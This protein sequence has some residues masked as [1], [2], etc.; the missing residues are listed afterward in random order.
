MH[1]R[2]LIGLSEDTLYDDEQ[3]SALMESWRMADGGQ[4]D[5]L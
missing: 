5:E 4:T 3:E 1:V 2:I